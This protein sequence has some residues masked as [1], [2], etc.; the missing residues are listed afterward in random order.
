[1]DHMSVSAPGTPI[2]L[3]LLSADDRERNAARADLHAAVQHHD[4]PY[5]PG[6]SRHHLLAQLTYP[7]PGGRNE[8]WL[9]FIGDSIVGSAEIYMPTLDNP[10]NAAIE[11]L[12]HPKHRR[13]GIGRQLALQAF[14]RARA[15]GRR[16]IVGETLE[17]GP[18]AVGGDRPGVAFARALGAHRALAESRRRLDLTTV[19][20]DVLERLRATLETTSLEYHVV[21]WERAVPDSLIDGVA[22]LET[23]MV[24]EA[25]MGELAW[26]PE[27]FDARRWRQQEATV[28]GRGRYT[29]GCASV[30]TASGE[31]AGY[32]LCAM[33]EDVPEHAWQWA[34]I[35]L[36]GHRGHRLGLRL[37]A[38]NLIRLRAAR[39]A[40][41]AI[42]TWNA[43][44]NAH[45]IA[46]NDELGF[47]P[48]DEWA[49]WQL[50][51]G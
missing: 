6:P 43:M 7:I 32:T 31:I 48:L 11:V 20:N 39:P 19:D 35:V 14:D 30:H 22:S 38:D 3:H 45:M 40:V 33:D 23:R 24:T 34:T 21:G 13:A 18:A 5:D 46:V 36:P 17:D 49:E 16:I 26:E 8:Y 12:V 9:A 15:N 2:A 10:T 27:Q 51:L 44:E 42:D 4:R 25:P 41:R 50:E 1:M 47:R 37:K 28:K 29:Y